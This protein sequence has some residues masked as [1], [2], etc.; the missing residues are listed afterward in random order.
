MSL[1]PIKAVLSEGL[2]SKAFHNQ[3]QLLPKILEE[4]KGNEVDL[5]NDGAFNAGTGFKAGYLLE[6]ER[7][8]EKVL[9]HAVLKDK[10]NLESRIKTL[11][12]D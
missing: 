2:N 6:L 1:D 7:M 4:P 12:K 8:I 9:P 11:K 3:L 10:P 5:H